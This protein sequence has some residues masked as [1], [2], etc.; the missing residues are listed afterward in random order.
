MNKHEIKQWQPK[1]D[2]I[3]RRMLAGDSKKKI[4]EDMKMGLKYLYVITGSEKF[5]AKFEEAKKIIVLSPNEDPEAILSKAQPIAAK[6]LSQLIMSD[7]EKIALE[8]IKELNKLSDLKIRE[9][10]VRHISAKDQADMEE[11]YKEQQEDGEN[12]FIISETPKERLEP[13]PS[14]PESP[15]EED[16]GTGEEESI[17]LLLTKILK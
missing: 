1:Y 16:E 10:E 2:I 11:F 9:R 7:N 14:E 17:F 15:R 3:I 4:A 12:P 13:T 5:Q 6:R 8:A